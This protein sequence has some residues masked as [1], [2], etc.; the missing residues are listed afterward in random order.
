MVVGLAAVAGPCLK[1][2]T[3]VNAMAD[4]MLRVNRETFEEVLKSG[5]FNCSLDGIED[6]RV[7]IQFFD[8]DGKKVASATFRTIIEG[9]RTETRTDWAKL[10]MTFSGVLESIYMV[11]ANATRE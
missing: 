5:P 11:K 9:C 10:E 1:V 6:G 7:R 3:E 2:F 4:A 8:G